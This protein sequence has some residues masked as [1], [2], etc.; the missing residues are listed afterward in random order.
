MCNKRASSLEWDSEEKVES[1]R[2]IKRRK[3][4]AEKA[5]HKK[6]KIEK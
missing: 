2:K 4:K 5:E 3:K 6:K 1:T